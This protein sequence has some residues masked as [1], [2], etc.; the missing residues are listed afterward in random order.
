MKRRQRNIDSL[1]SPLAIRALLAQ[2]QVAA[3]EHFPTIEKDQIALLNALRY[4]QVK[5][6]KR[7]PQGRPSPWQSATLNAVSEKL[8]RILAEQTGGRVSLQ[9]F[10]CQYLPL[11][12]YPPDILDALSQGDLNRQE[13]LSLARLSAKRLQTS[14]AQARKLRQQLMRNHLLAQG[15][16]NQLR[17]R[18]QEM[19]G[20]SSL[21]SRETLALGVMKADALLE[22]DADDVKHIFFETIKDLFYA[23]RDLEPDD[24]QDADIAAVMQAAD[25]LSNTLR[26]INQRK[27]KPVERYSSQTFDS[28]NQT[29]ESNVQ[30]QEDPATGFLIY[31]FPDSR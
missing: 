2:L 5:G 26:S 18:V 3:P 15:S 1:A 25:S 13:A 28:Q 17:Q 9:T 11:L 22:V 4:A 19:L 21:L 31:Q 8:Q 16:Q 12:N 23:I 29:T 20:Q 30:L 24:L 14:E 7:T 6:S 27:L 10:I